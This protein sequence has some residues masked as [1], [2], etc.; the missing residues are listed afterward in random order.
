MLG[1][2]LWAALPVL[3]GCSVGPDFKGVQSQLPNSFFNAPPIV[4]EVHAPPSETV[5][6]PVDPN[7]W[8]LFGDTQLTA[9]E[10]QIAG[11]N[12]NL[13]VLSR[14]FSQARAQV[15]LA[16]SSLF[17][18]LGANGSYSRELLSQNGVIALFPTGGGGN[19]SFGSLG[20]SA[21]G[22]GGTVGAIPNTTAIPPF[23]LYQ[24]GFDAS[25][26]IDIWGRIRRGV[27]ASK[28]NLQAAADNVRGSLISTQA[29]LARD[30]IQ[31][32]GAQRN[33]E[34]TRENLDSAQQS[35][36]LT[37]ERAA[38]GLTNDLD[39]AQAQA[40][41]ATVAA[42]LPGL[43]QQESLMI[44]AISLLMGAPPRALQ[45][46]LIDAKPIPPVPPLVPVGLPA[47]LVRRRPDIRA[48]EAQLHAATAQI[49]VATAAFFPD[50][51]ITG[52]FGF[53]SL[54]LSNLASWRSAQYGVGPQFTLP[55][56]Q[57]GQLVSTLHL[58][59]QMQQEAA[60]NYQ[61]VV[62]QSLHDVD[63]ALTAYH[64]EQQRRDQLQLAVDA[65]QRALKLARERYI[66]GISTFLDVLQAQRDL[67]ATQQQ[68]TDSTSTV[69]TD[70]V[71]LYKALGGGWE[72]A[73]PEKPG[74]RGLPQPQPQAA[75]GS[76]P[77]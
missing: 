72:D 16:Q 56:F 59:Q 68:L 20:S 54:M 30:Y 48:A 44:N 13:A 9:L 17:P 49:G 71:A 46:E 3:A 8:K 63:N 45:S 69:S 53:Q 47:Q 15:G 37:R 51:S 65:N 40:E 31:L 24:G 41:V 25:W 14:R 18:Q 11:A 5:A 76:T 22:L 35:L 75:N 26:E 39:V 66:Q 61:Q 2:F 52:S 34:I 62:L 50:V 33:L 6:D 43:Q 38:T 64:A 58:R 55:I 74:P 4:Q 12:L 10:G 70:L 21:N 57:G 36:K 77:L 27:E 29:E 73:Y 42:Q 28:A 7:W 60:V 32:R 67:L 1:T 19:S 23:N